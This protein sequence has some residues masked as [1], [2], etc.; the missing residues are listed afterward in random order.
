MKK[1][2]GNTDRIMRIILAT[3]F[4]ALYATGTVS[5]NSGFILLLLGAY[6]L[7]TAAISL[8][9]LYNLLGINTDSTKK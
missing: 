6:F 2:M 5:G 9:P 7:A 3:L 4:A 1:N 8:C